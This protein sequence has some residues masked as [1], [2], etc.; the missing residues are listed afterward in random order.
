M[1]IESIVIKENDGGK[2]FNVMKNVSTHSMINA[3]DGEL[4]LRLEIE[5]IGKKEEETF[6]FHFHKPAI[7][8]IREFEVQAPGDQSIYM[9]F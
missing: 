7:L 5:D 1:N 2:Q 4:Q 8:N 3:N 6:N 9:Q